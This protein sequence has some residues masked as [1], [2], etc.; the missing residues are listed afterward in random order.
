MKAKTDLICICLSCFAFV[1]CLS[2]FLT[3]RNLN[4]WI[5]SS[6]RRVVH[7]EHTMRRGE[8]WP[9]LLKN[10][11]GCLLP[12]DKIP[13]IL[14]CSTNNAAFPKVLYPLTEE[15]SCLSF[16]PYM[17]ILKDAPG[18]MTS[19]NIL[20]GA[21]AR[22]FSPVETQAL[23]FANQRQNLQK[24][25]APKQLIILMLLFHTHIQVRCFERSCGVLLH[26]QQ[27]R[28]QSREETH[29]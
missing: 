24:Q 21:E 13:Q 14:L 4:D 9:P 12:F 2:R 27:E 15:W 5:I 1:S 7:L 8:R 25:Q 28:G 29:Q 10:S 3:R 16:W 23:R 6:V 17:A 20:M 11:R 22:V 19:A 18:P 26:T